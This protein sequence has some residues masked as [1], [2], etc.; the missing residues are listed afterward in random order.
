MLSYA[1]DEATIKERFFRRIE[2]IWELDYAREKVPMFPVRWA[3]SIQKEG[4]Y[5]TTIIIPGASAKNTSAKNE[6]WVLTSQVDQCYFITDPSK[7]AVL[8]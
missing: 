2:E 4:R 3:K 7:Q 6:P 5:F 1:D 8:S